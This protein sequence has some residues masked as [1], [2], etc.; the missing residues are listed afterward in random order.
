MSMHEWLM[1][2]LNTPRTH[3]MGHLLD[4]QTYTLLMYRCGDMCTYCGQTKEG[5][6]KYG[7]ED[8]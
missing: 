4:D 6:Q 5:C 1:S 3:E 8:M 2:Q 7:C